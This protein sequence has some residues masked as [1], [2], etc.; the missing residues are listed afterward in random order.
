MKRSMSAAVAAVEAAVGSPVEA[1]VANIE[2]YL[3]EPQPQK[4]PASKLL[5]IPW[6]E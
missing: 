1:A 6:A 4:N 2:F 5:R 3:I